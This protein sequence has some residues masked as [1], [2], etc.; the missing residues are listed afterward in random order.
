MRLA[1]VMYGHMRTYKQ[2]FP[3][4]KKHLIDVYH[5]DF[6]I[7]TWDEIEAKTTSW[8]QSHMNVT[9]IS[10][11]ELKSIKDMY[12]PISMRMES[13]NPDLLND[14]AGGNNISIQ[15][16]KFMLYSLKK[17]D[18]LRL[19]HDRYL[20][21]RYDY[22]LKLRPDVKFFKDL[23]IPEIEENTVLISARKKGEGDSISSYSV[24][25]IVNIARSDTMERICNAVMEFENFYMK[26]PAVHSAWIDFILSQKIN[27]VFSKQVY[28]STEDWA[29]LR[30]DGYA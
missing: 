3:S 20:G 24:C 27:I 6:F 13:Q 16:Q 25:D 2:C 9:N 28:G 23:I 11:A 15:G 19:Q 14:Y 17:A 5:P 12:K 4:V 29:I 30:K 26:S 7:H 10:S 18:C 8:H 1:V 21:R 22:V